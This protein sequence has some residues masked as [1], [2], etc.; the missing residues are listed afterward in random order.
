MFTY[1]TSVLWE[2][3]EAIE[4]IS[5]FRFFLNLLKS[6]LGSY[7]SIKQSKNWGSAVLFSS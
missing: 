1:D 6:F 5:T 3:G 4:K 7:I 2:V